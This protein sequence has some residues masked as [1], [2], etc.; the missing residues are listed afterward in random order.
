TNAASPTIENA[1]SGLCKSPAD[2]PASPTSTPAHAATT[3]PF[4]IQRPVARSTTGAAKPAIPATNAQIKRS[5]LILPPYYLHYLRPQKSLRTPAQFHLPSRET[6]GKSPT[7]P[8]TIPPPRPPATPAAAAPHSKPLWAS[9][10]LP[11]IANRARNQAH[12]HPPG[13]TSEIPRTRQALP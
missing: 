10:A 8:K 13:P 12:A 7:P 5:S 11:S 2:I 1:A 9:P 6:A 3:I 4:P